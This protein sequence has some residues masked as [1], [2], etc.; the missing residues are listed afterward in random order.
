[1]QRKR[2]LDMQTAKL[3]SKGQTT[4]PV[5]VRDFLALN[6]GDFINFTFEHNSVHIKK[7]EPFDIEYHRALESTL[8][9]EWNSKEDND[10]YKHL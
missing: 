5:E 10:A 1:M 7:A 8:S 3:T 6:P 4:I 9:A 2:N